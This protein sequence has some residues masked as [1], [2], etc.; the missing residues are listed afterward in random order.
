MP[1]RASRSTS[2]A[3]PLDS[4]SSGIA[5]EDATKA[6]RATPANSSL[7]QF[8]PYLPVATRYAARKVPPNEVDDVVQDS[9]VRIMSYCLDAQVQHPKSYLIMVVRTVIVDR[10]RHDTSRH[11]KDHCELIE[12]HHPVDTLCPCRILA[13]RQE[14]QNVMDRLNAVPGR[15]R[16]M[17]FA[18]RVEGSTF[19]ATAERYGVSVS[20]V[21]KQVSRVLAYLAE[22]C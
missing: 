12:T 5:S 2:F 1:K 13:G 3:V 15:T 6:N 21:E 22:G 9:L 19:K 14:L 16:E 8:L 10:M 18:I 11:R 20:T 4:L 7:A 17:L